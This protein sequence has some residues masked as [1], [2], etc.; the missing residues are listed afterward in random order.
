MKLTNI[1]KKYDED[2]IFEN[3]NLNFTKNNIYSIFGRNGVGKTTLLNIMGGNLSY[4]KGEIS[5]DS[6]DIIFIEN[7]SIPFEFMTADE[8][9]DITFSF[10]SGTYDL[11]EK[12]KLYDELN[13]HE[14]TKLIQ[15]FSKGMK[16][17]LLLVIALLAKP[18]ILLL[19]EP[20]SDLDT[21]TFKKITKQFKTKK[22]EMII[23][24]STHIPTIAYKFSDRLIFLSKKGA[25]EMDNHFTTIEK[26]E[27][28]IE[29]HIQYS[30]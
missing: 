27:I 1:A 22:S 5:K 30:N 7:N 8:F 10:K 12:A 21:V 29:K 15:D 23:I 17:K 6:D 18:K 24:F 25:I 26:L 9:I 13:F 14:N 28:Q 3:V 2:Y 19:D 16:S 11:E 20:F 4:D